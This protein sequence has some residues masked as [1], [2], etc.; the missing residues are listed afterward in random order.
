MVSNGRI[1]ASSDKG[2]FISDDFCN[3]W[4]SA[5]SGIASPG[6][7]NQKSILPLPNNEI[8]YSNGVELYKS[9]NNGNS[10]VALSQSPTSIRSII[11]ESVSNLLVCATQTGVHVSNDL[12]Q[13]WVMENTGLTSLNLM[14]L[15]Y[16]N[17]V[18][19]CGSTNSNIFVSQNNSFQ[20]SLAS[21]LTGTYI[22]PRIIVANNLLLANR[23]TGVH[24]YNYNTSQFELS[25]LNQSFPVAISQGLNQ[26]F[27][28]GEIV[29]NKPDYYNSVYT[30][31]PIGINWNFTRGLRNSA[32]LGFSQLNDDKLS[33]DFAGAGCYS[34]SLDS[35]Y[36]IIG[37]PYVFGSISGNI[38]NSL[39]YQ[40]QK[41]YCA[42]NSGIWISN[43]SAQ[44]WVQHT[45]GLPQTPPSNYFYTYDLEVFGDTIVVSTDLG[46]YVSTNGG[47]SFSISYFPGTTNSNDLL[48]HNGKLYSAG[49][50][51]M[52]VS[53]NLG[54]NWAQFGSQTAGFRELAAAGPYI[55]SAS[56]QSI[57]MTIDTIGIT[58]DVTGT[59]DLYIGQGNN[60]GIAAYDTLLFVSNF[61]NVGV[62]KMN[63]NNI[64]VYTDVSDN[65]PHY[66][67]SPGQFRY[68]YMDN[69]CNM[70]IF[71]NKLW[72][73]TAGMSCFTR[74]LSDFGYPPVVVTDHKK[75]EVKMEATELKVFPNPVRDELNVQINCHGKESLQIIISDLT[76]SIVY[77]ENINFNCGTL[78]IPIQQLSNG[79]YLIKLSQRNGNFVM[80]KFV[81]Q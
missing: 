46:P 44:T 54:A 18:W 50:P 37:A 78:Q 12:G 39:K 24:V 60:P 75:E 79:I 58:A 48:Y 51:K 11:F 68:P 49:T 21:G 56:D 67:S 77:H 71:D 34:A 47:N 42:T 16:L 81:K 41:F 36:Y 72:L 10:W 14:L 53:T 64:G 9:L 73:G 29:S 38:S 28:G 1:F 76:G 52:L 17:G 65:L 2:I 57:H 3:S 62:Q 32:V 7:V 13:N 27:Y 35:S 33:F 31:S 63:V 30:N 19:V 59:L 74:P 15:E 8:L 80:N 5:N 26:I 20:W 22:N 70:T 40:N 6:N 25:T 61:Y 45:T 69:G 66:V 43:D 23:T 4:T 55:Y